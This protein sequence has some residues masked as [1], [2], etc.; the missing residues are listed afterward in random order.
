V[1]EDFEV[2][3]MVAT[4]DTIKRLMSYPKCRSVEVKNNSTR[5]GSNHREVDYI[6][7]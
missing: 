7:L 3:E 1:L 6:K 4:C 5:L 2:G